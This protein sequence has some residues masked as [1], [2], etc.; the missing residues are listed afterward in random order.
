MDG[1]SVGD[2]SGNN[3]RNFD[4]N[5]FIYIFPYNVSY[6]PVFCGSTNQNSANG[7]LWQLELMLHLTEGHTS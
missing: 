3:C 2:F 6:I 7:G 1:R 4:E 5:W